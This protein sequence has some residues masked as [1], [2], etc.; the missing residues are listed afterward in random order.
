MRSRLLRSAALGL[1]RRDSLATN[2]C[3]ASDTSG[4]ISTF[5]ATLSAASYALL[6]IQM[7]QQNHRTKV[8]LTGSP[9]RLAIGV[10]H[11]AL[12]PTRAR[13]ALRTTNIKE[14]PRRN[15]DAP[16]RSELYQAVAPQPAAR[17]RRACR[18][19]CLAV[20]P[21]RAGPRGRR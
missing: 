5:M 15:R 9:L 2:G 20:R 13:K 21:D 7:N 17:R 18:W 10:Q 12:R 16:R 1:M 8:A 14:S 6:L 11:S 19:C 3:P 4:A